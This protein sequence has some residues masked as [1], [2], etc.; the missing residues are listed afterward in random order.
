[1][2]DEQHEAFDEKPLAAQV[3]DLRRDFQELLRCGTSIIAEWDQLQARMRECCVA[4][5]RLTDVVQK[6]QGE[7]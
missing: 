6:L 4:A 3:E 1:M 7:Q 2:D 5:D